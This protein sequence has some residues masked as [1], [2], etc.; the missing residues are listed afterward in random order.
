M[1]RLTAVKTDLLFTAEI[2]VLRTAMT[3]I[4]DVSEENG[5]YNYIG[6]WEPLAGLESGA[7]VSRMTEAL[8]LE[9]TVLRQKT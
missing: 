5:S 6:L 8:K 3:K 7:G 9:S 1:N 4:M 2:T